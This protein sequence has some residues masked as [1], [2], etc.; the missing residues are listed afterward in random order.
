MHPNFLSLPYYQPVSLTAQLAGRQVR[1]FSKPG[2]PNWQQV[3]PA[4]S[5]LVE[6]AHLAPA[7]LLW[8]INCG[9]GALAASVALRNPSSQCWV[10]DSDLLALNCNRLTQSDHHLDNLF[11]YY[12]IDIPPAIKGNLDLSLMVIPKGRKL[13]R[14]WLLQVWQVLKPGG[15]LLLAGPNDQGIRS[16]IKDAAQ[17]F[18]SCIILD[19]KKGNRVARFIKSGQ[20]GNLPEWTCE[21]GIALGSWVSFTLDVAG[22]AI[23]VHSLPGLFSSTGLDPGSQLLLEALPDLSGHS[24]LDV[25]CG[26]GILGMVAAQNGAS[27]VD[28]VDNQL[29]AIACASRNIEQNQ[30]SNCRAV[31]SDLLSSVADNTYSFILTNPPFHAGKQVDYQIAESLIASAF[32]VLQ[33]GGILQLVA[34]RFIRYDRWMAELFGNVRLIA[35]S[36]A[37]HVLSSCKEKV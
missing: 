20:A 16:A 10:S 31:M 33:P 27:H 28:L 7:D 36:P 22:H 23:K 6:H 29:P 21:P 15:R 14:H 2:L 12:D 18:H 9:S 26:Y 4:V 37:Y 35:E 11:I 25:G 3:S 24:V 13:A 32:D 1:Y 30:F 5:L 34:N 19:Y 17:L 8:L